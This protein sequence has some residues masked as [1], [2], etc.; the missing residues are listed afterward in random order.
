M[1]AVAETGK[2]G[3]EAKKQA[4]ARPAP[5]LIED[6]ACDHRGACPDL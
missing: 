2:A 5:V 1:N 6:G 3:P 4:E